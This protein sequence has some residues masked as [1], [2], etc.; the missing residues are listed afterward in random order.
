MKWFRFVPHHLVRDY[1]DTG[2]HIVNVDLAHHGEY[3]ALLQWLCDCPLTE[4][5]NPDERHPHVLPVCDSASARSH[6]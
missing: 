6:V 4:P 1:L 3:A 2:W 5:R